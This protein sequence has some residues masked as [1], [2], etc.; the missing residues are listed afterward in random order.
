MAK[1]NDLVFKAMNLVHRHLFNA[2]KGRVGGRALG[3]PVVMLTTRGRRSGQPRTSML[4]SPT[5]DG[6]TMVLVASRGGDDRHPAWFLNL[7]EHPEVD[8]VTGGTR[9][10]MRAVV[11]SAEKKKRLWPAVV[12]AYKGYA[13]Y[14]S[15]TDRDIPLVL[16]HPIRPN[17]PIEPEAATGDAEPTEPAG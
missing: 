15:R 9:A 17:L 8:V 11:A 4:T 3:M 13:T 2:T 7:R 12:E 1:Q 10:K 14:Q 5:T 16:L 6:D